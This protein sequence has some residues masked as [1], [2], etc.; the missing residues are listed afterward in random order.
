MRVTFNRQKLKGWRAA[1]VTA[2][3]LVLIAPIVLATSAILMFG[4]VLFAVSAIV[5]F[6]IKAA[7]GSWPKWWEPR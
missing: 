7:T 6:A 3:C 5:A 2:L 4:V 1:L